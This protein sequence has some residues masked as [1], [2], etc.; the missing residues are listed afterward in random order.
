MAIV[1]SMLLGAGVTGGLLIPKLLYTE[2]ID[3]DQTVTGLRREGAF[4]GIQAFI[5]RFASGI[6]ALI[7]SGIMAAFGYVE[8][9]AVQA[10]G[11]ATGFRVSMS[12]VL[13]VHYYRRYYHF[14]LPNPR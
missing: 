14:A 1:L 9:V 4:Y 8:G 2:I 6:E 12:L 10:T 11:A 5:I 13:A 3:E 7:L